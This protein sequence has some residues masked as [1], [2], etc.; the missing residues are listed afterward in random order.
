MSFKGKKNFSPS[1]VVETM[2]TMH[3]FALI[4]E[5]LIFNYRKMHFSSLNSFRNRFQRCV[6]Q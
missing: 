3:N 2:Q 6:V 1:V 5:L 4:F